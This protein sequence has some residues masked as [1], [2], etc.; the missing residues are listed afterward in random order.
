MVLVGMVGVAEVA[1]VVLIVSSSDVDKR[2][3][4]D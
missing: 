2:K 4:I 1:M 3:V